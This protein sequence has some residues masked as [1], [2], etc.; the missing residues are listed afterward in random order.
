MKELKGVIALIPTPVT[1]EGK[2]DEIGLR[3]IMDYDLDNGCFGVGVAAAIGEGY[4]LSKEDEEKVI[5]TAV[6]HMNGR[7]PVIVGTPALGTNQAVE[8]CKRAEDLGADAVLT[9]NPKFRGRKPYS[10]SELIDHYGAI[11]EAVKIHVVPYSQEDDLIPFEVLKQLVDEKRI[12]HLKY[13]WNDCEYLKKITQYLGD[14]LF[15]FVG[16]DTY[17]LRYLLLGAQGISTATAAVFPK[18]NSRLLS[19]VQAGEIEL[20][21]KLYNDKIVPWNDCGFYQRWHVCHKLA[22][23]LMGVID[24][25]QCLP[26]LTGALA[27]YQ[28]EEIKWLLKHQGLI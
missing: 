10:D 5:K 14:R 15:V 4:L 1:G 21:R 3:K 12:A 25:H 13:A 23:Q 2:L 20:A 18:D 28:V 7:G 6:E 26:P 22:L 11:T 27:D 16:A 17:T 9:F 19:L 24:S 8:R